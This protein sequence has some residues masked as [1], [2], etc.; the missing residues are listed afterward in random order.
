MANRIKHAPY[1]LIAA[2]VKDY[3]KPGIGLTLAQHAHLG[4]HLTLVIDID[5]APQTLDCF[6]GRHALDLGQVNFWD[7]TF[8]G[9]NVTREITV[10]SQQQQAFSV[11]I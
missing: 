3:F 6:V 8:C 11:E 7:S 5:T 9:G 2:F 1:L 4:A 10:V